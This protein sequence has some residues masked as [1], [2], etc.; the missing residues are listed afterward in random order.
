M[1][2][3]TSSRVGIRSCLIYNKIH[4]DRLIDLACL[5]RLMDGRLQDLQG[6][7]VGRLTLPQQPRSTSAG[8]QHREMDCT[9][10]RN[11]GEDVSS[12]APSAAAAL[13]APWSKQQAPSTLVVLLII[14][15]VLPEGVEYVF[16]LPAFSYR[17][18]APRLGLS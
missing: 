13:A 16:F 11:G 14:Q 5:R 7:I 10:H 3:W 17:A 4:A 8:A 1:K 18:A 15:F 12:L 9:V 6:S 2:P